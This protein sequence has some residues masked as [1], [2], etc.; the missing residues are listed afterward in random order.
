MVTNSL[1]CSSS[2]TYVLVNML[3]TYQVLRNTGLLLRQQII[4]Q[5]LA[6]DRHL[7]TYLSWF[8]NALT[9]SAYSYTMKHK[10]G[11]ELE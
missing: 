8:I 9:L 10:S 11:Q 2:C 3:V 5:L 4:L 7:C 1:E 6:M